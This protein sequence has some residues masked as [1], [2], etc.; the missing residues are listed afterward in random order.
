MSFPVSFILIGSPIIEL[1]EI[2]AE[3]LVVTQLLDVQ[4]IKR[5]QAVGTIPEIVP[6]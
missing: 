4:K 5:R 2:M 6:P 1:S 3:K